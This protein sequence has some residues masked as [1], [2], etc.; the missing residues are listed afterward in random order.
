MNSANYID[1]YEDKKR[2]TEAFPI[3]FHHL[4]STHLRYVMELHWHLD[5]EF[6][7]VT[8]GRLLLTLNGQTFELNDGDTAFIPSGLLHSAVPQQDCIYD[9]AVIGQNLYYPEGCWEQIKQIQKH[10]KEVQSIYKKEHSLMCGYIGNI[11]NAGER[12][13]E[14]GIR[15]LMI[16]GALYSFLSAALNDYPKSEVAANTPQSE[17]RI[18]QIKQALEYIEKNYYKLITLKE[19]AASIGMSP[20]YFC[21]FFKEMT[22]HSPIEYLNCYR[23]ERACDLLRFSNLSIVDISEKT[24]F[25]DTSYFIKMFKK[26]KNITPKQYQIQMK[27]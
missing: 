25:H 10:K 17:R 22:L 13:A 26:H 27:D 4:T 15:E 8:Q 19:L 11:F 12:S 14:A 2:G 21:Q 24:G 9:C 23:I 7:R 18:T 1:F 20:K 5:F 16:R 6:I 3:E